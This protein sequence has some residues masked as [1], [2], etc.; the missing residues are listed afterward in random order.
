M[1]VMV[2]SASPRNLEVMA[3][4]FGKGTAL[5]WLA[6]YYGAPIAGTMAFGDYTNDM[7]LLGAAGWPV[8]MGNAVAP[9]KAVARIIAPADVED[10]VAQI[11]ERVLEGAL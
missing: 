4:G 7:E 1:D 11:L 8:A 9:L 10:G 2:S 3:A 6:D 5:R